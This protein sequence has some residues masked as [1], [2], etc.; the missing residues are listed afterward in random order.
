VRVN[1]FQ[2]QLLVNTLGTDGS[3]QC[4]LF[5]DRYEL[6]RL[7]RPRSTCNWRS[8]LPY[9]RDGII[10]LASSARVA[11]LNVR[12]HCWS[13]LTTRVH[14]VAA[15][16]YV[17]TSSSAAGALR[18]FYRAGLRSEQTTCRDKRAFLWYRVVLRRTSA[19]SAPNSSWTAKLY[20]SCHRTSF[21]VDVTS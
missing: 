20:M 6:S 5:T 16:E 13:D 4:L 7:S 8:N 14:D 3:A 12:E 9:A 17:L 18:R 1:F 21:N 15:H 19:A 11:E 2:A 10:L